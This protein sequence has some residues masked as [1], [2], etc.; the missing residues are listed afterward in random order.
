[1][2]YYQVIALS[3]ILLAAVAAVYAA[4]RAHRATTT[5]SD[6]WQSV[7]NHQDAARTAVLAQR[8]DA[9]YA[10]MEQD[11]AAAREWRRIHFETYYQKARGTWDHSLADGLGDYP[12]PIMAARWDGWCMR[13][14]ATD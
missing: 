7:R 2:D 4:W 13:G 5:A 3:A 14:I 12:D 11:M 6:A 9:H 10:R 1:M 8:D